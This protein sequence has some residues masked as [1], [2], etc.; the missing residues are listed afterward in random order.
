[1][2]LWIATQAGLAGEPLAQEETSKNDRPKPI[3]MDT[4]DRDGF[5][6]FAFDMAWDPSTAERWLNDGYCQNFEQRHDPGPI[7]KDRLASHSRRAA[8]P[9]LKLLQASKGEKH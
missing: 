9:L 5:V 1:M 3:Y 6:N 2:A 4:F 7:A 8:P